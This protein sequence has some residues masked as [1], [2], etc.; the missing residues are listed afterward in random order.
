MFDPAS[1][2]QNRSLYT[3]FFYLGSSW[4]NLVNAISFFQE[5]GLTC[6][7]FEA[8]RIVPSTSQGGIS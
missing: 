2:L 7:Q 8:N 4:V 3:S 1:F 5:P 6:I